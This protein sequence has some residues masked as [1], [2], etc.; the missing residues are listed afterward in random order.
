[1]GICAKLSHIRRKGRRASEMDTSIQLAPTT[2]QPKLNA[3]HQSPRPLRGQPVEASQ[4][5]QTIVALKVA[6]DESPSLPMLAGLLT[7]AVLL[8]VWS[9]G[10]MGYRYLPWR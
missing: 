9:H 2:R 7:H 8:G 4:L 1:M 5:E 6:A 10:V 3:A